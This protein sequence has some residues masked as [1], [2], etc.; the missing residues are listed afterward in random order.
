MPFSN[1]IAKLTFASAAVILFLLSYTLYIQINDLDD[2]YDKVNET[3]I[4]KLKLEQTLSTVK[5]AETAQ[6]GFLLTQDSSFLEP[7][8]GGYE[9]ARSLIT[10]IKSLTGNNVQQQR[11]LNALS[12]FIEVRFKSFS[13][14]INQYNLPETNATSKKL[15]LLTGKAGMD[16]I[17]YH[18]QSIADEEDRV[19]AQREEKKLSHRYMTPFL[20]FLL[21]IT[22]LTMLIFSYD[23]IIEQLNKTKKLLFQLRGLNNKLKQKNHELELYNKELD[24]FT[25]IASHDLKEPLRKILTFSTLI[26]EGEQQFSEKGKDN[27]QRILHAARRMQHLLDDLLQYSHTS[28]M[29]KEFEEVDLN[30]ILTEVQFSL[31]EEIEDCQAVIQV[32]KLPVV[33]GLSFQLKQLFENLI[34][35]SIKYR[36][37]DVAPRITIF[38]SFISRDDVTVATYAESI[39]YH[40]IVY[41]DNGQGFSQVYAEKIFEL[42][43]RVHSRNADAGGNGIGLTIC[44]KI[45]Q[46]HNG[47]I[48]ARSAVNMGTSFEIYLPYEELSTYKTTETPFSM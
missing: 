32:D 35:N 38:C 9:K 25:Y 20:A 47:F 8:L 42:F 22:A 2:S 10:E 5:D 36:K 29:E 19:L 30:H 15:Q 43:K 6:R 4:V 7:Y 12:T 33:R 27:L 37:P 18:I 40:K 17:R 23:K 26:E 1:K 13:A 3:H 34:S 11:N 48:T 45:A 39:F 24:S 28:L 41:T 14:Q 44:K 46:N 16:S 21:I 31:K